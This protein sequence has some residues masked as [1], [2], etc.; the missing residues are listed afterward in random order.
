MCYD[1]SQGP[2]TLGHSAMVEQ[3]PQ[4]EKEEEPLDLAE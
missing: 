3:G 1:R 4:V 2:T